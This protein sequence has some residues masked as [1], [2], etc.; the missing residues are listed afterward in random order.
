M[1]EMVIMTAKE[2]NR[3]ARRICSDD[4]GKP[5][6]CI[7]TLIWASFSSTLVVPVV[8]EVEF[9]LRTDSTD[10]LCLTARLTFNTFQPTT[11][12]IPK[13]MIKGM[14]A[15]IPQVNWNA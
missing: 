7:G 6:T 10:L 5:S 4:V 8:G 14:P 12:N 13:E 3:V 2:M 9:E 11:A 15:N 1:A